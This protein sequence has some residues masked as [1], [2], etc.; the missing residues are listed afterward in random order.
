MSF[1]TEYS[2]WFALVCILVGAIYSFI[3]Y[4]KNKNTAYDRRA[5]RVMFV[6]RGVAVALIAFLLLAPMLRLTVKRTEK[7]IIVVGIDNTESIISIPDSNFY[8]TTFK[9]NY[10]SFIHHLQKNYEV[11]SYALGANAQLIKDDKTLNFSEKSTNLSTLFDEINNYYLSRN[12]G[13]VVLFTD[14]IFY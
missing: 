6:F 11:V 8:T 13:A 7:P 5:M 3:L 14:G 4:Y 2:L 1:L 10:E 12:I 9:A